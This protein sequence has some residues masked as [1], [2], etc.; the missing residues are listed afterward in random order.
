MSL[1]KPS[2][3][4]LFL[5]VV[6][7]LLVFSVLFI[8]GYF[9]ESLLRYQARTESLQEHLENQ[10]NTLYEQARDNPG[11]VATLEFKEKVNNLLAGLQ[12]IQLEN[13]FFRREMALYSGFI[14]VFLLL[15][16]SGVFVAAYNLITRPL[17]RLK[18]STRLVAR[19]DLTVQVAPCHISDIDSLIT[20]FNG[21]ISDLQS[22]HQRLVA[23]EKELAWREMARVLAHE[24]KN[25]L[26]PIR[27][28]VERLQQKQAQGAEN[29]AEAVSQAAEII[30]EE[31]QNLQKLVDSFSRF[32]RLPVPAFA[33]VDLRKIITEVFREYASEAD[34]QIL[35]PDFPLR[36]QGDEMLLRQLLVNLVQNSL[37]SGG[38]EVLKV[39]I[40]AV[41]S[42]GQVRFW[43]LDN[44]AGIPPENLERIFQPYFTTRSRGT[45]LGLAIARRIVE[46][47]QGTITVK[48]QPGQ[49]ARFLVTLP[50]FLRKT[51][52]PQSREN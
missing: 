33:T 39:E 32:A 17:Q 42:A 50:E 28:A 6:L 38:E 45:G 27:L 9:M 2:L 34:F 25:P 21:M 11:F 3:R 24:I 30:R 35:L 29:L 26:T 4:S 44:G 12:Q 23:L 10:I 37:E 8:R 13:E 1:H 52:E 48:S 51:G 19:G 46:V 7:V 22:H 31:V 40:G 14:V 43:V 20:S 41:S 36:L 15:A 16:V 18:E 5:V 49:G 47:H